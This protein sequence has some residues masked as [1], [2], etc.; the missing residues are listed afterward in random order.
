[1]ADDFLGVKCSLAWIRS[2]WRS[3]VHMD[4]Q[5]S[6]QEDKLHR[7]KILRNRCDENSALETHFIVNGWQKLVKSSFLT[8]E[9]D[10]TPKC[11]NDSLIVDMFGSSFSQKKTGDDAETKTPE[12]PARA[13]PRK[14]IAGIGHA[15]SRVAAGFGRDAMHSRPSP[16]QRLSS[17]RGG[18]RAS[19]GFR[20]RGP[21]GTSW[22]AASSST[23]IWVSPGSPQQGRRARTL[24]HGCGNQPRCL[25]LSSIPRATTLATGKE[26]GG[27]QRELR[28][29]SADSMVPPSNQ[30]SP[31]AAPTEDYLVG[32]K[33][34][35]ASPVHQPWAGREPSDG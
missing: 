24:P 2:I 21:G 18:G 22:Q 27:F 15:I 14:S 19:A 13:K 33:G 7:L 1:M 17:L 28:W 8:P 20:H 34:P 10:E 9:L 12:C 6:S 25:P 11:L 32:G 4:G 29:T 31:P 35:Q 5:T 3:F 30:G 16:E 23:A 26:G